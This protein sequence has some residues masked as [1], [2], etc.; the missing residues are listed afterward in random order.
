MLRSGD[1]VDMIISQPAFYSK[2][3]KDLGIESKVTVNDWDAN[4][5][6][7]IVLGLILSKSQFSEQDVAKM[8]GIVKAMKQDLTNIHHDH[9]GARHRTGLRDPVAHGAR[10]PAWSMRKQLLLL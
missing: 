5:K 7:P 3:L 6:K 9:L 8:T 4:T 10:Q 1:R 2:E